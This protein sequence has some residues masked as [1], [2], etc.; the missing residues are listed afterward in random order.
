MKVPREDHVK[1]APKT[2][3]FALVTVSS[4]RYLA[5]LRGEEFSDESQELAA[6][7]IEESGHI[8]DVRDLVDDDVSMI[9]LKL[10]ELVRRKDLDVIVFIGGTGFSRKDV[11]IEAV[12][13]F[14]EKKVDGFGE[15][16]RYLSFKEV[17][18]AA[19]LSRA[20]MGIVENKVVMC[21]PG[22][23]NAVKLALE[24]FVSELPHLLYVLRS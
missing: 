4:S 19:F 21:L 11:T 8:V 9:R 23:P 22:S 7:L 10:M 6:K 3:K 2:L 15:L 1:H 13:P 5:K 14:F 16:F 24:N 18:A 12:E 20:M 17:G